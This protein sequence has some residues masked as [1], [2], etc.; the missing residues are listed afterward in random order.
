MP[1][2]TFLLAHEDREAQRAGD[3]LRLLPV[4]QLNRAMARKY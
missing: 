3:W 1:E 2:G 4:H